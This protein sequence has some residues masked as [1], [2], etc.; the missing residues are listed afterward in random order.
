MKKLTTA[1]T[2]M[3]AKYYK[4]NEEKWR[5][6]LIAFPHFQTLP[7]KVHKVMHARQTGMFIDAMQHLQEA[8]FSEQSKSFF[9]EV[10]LIILV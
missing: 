9:T 10:W 2:D 3:L 5:V 1:E 8:A 6:S 7:S 4:P